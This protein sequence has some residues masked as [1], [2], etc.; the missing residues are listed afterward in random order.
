MEQDF[1]FFKTKMPA[2]RKAEYYLGCLEGAVFI[3]FNQAREGL[4]SMC[5]ITF[6]GYGCYEI[7]TQA[8][9]LNAEMSKTFIEEFTNEPD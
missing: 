4:I 9:Y 5:R 2:S 1:H 3:D 6:D 8:G 7:P